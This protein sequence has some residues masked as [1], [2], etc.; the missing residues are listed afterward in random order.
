VALGTGILAAGGGYGVARG[1]EPR[2]ESATTR[3][4]GTGASGQE[5]FYGAHQGGIATEPQ[6]RVVFGA[7]DVTSTKIEDLVVLL[8]SWSAAAAR[9]AS[10]DQSGPARTSQDDPPADTGEAVGLPPGQLTISVGFGPSLF[11][12]RFGVKARRPAALVDLPAFP[13]DALDPTRC[14]GDLGVQA[15]AN[16]PVVAFHAVR[17]FMRIARGTAVLRWSQQ[18]FGRNSAT[19]PHGATG[20]NLMGFK[21]GTKNIAVDNETDLDAFVWVGDET[22]QPWMHGGSYG[23]TRRIRMFIESWDATHLGEQEDVFGRRKDTGAPFT[24]SHELDHVD[25]AAAGSSGP[26]IP[27]DA[28]IRL[29][30][31]ATNGGQK[32]LR[33][34]YHFSDGAD[35]MTGQLDAGLFF[36]GYQKDPRKQFVPIQT[37]LS[38]NDALN[39]Y[40]EH[41]GSA[42]FAFPPGL[43]HGGEWYGQALFT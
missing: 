11:D 42:I 39:E 1:T 38:D 23:V 31:P 2:S 29:A 28:H 7:F 33:R 30:A 14:G 37:R 16:D 34:G 3:A 41:N 18:G 25:L 6:D 5:P 12:D 24:G 26:M 43:R 9:M 27:A 13:T 4:P 21:D 22:D 35:P 19:S 8:Q 17:N 32:I 20:R 40:I 36:I 15:C 10:G